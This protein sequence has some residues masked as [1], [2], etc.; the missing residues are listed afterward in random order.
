MSHPYAKPRLVASFIYIAPLPRFT[1]TAAQQVTE[2][3]TTAL[4]VRETANFPWGPQDPSEWVLN[5]S[6][7]PGF[8]QPTV[9]PVASRYTDW[10]IPAANIIE[11]SYLFFFAEQIF[12]ETK[13]SISGI[14]LHFIIKKSES[15]I[16][17]N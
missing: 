16:L 13:E 17:Y 9:Q 7:T 15:C 3:V 1:Q 8:E 14:S 5:I 6:P 11:I 2:T 10:A 12:S 4:R